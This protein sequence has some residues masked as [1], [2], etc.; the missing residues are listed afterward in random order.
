[1]DRLAQF[2]RRQTCK[3]SRPARP[4]SLPTGASVLYRTAVVTTPHVVTAKRRTA[5]SALVSLL[6]VSGRL[7]R[8]FPRPE[9]D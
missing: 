6:M 4:K 7:A 8:A 3:Q 9:T 1:M 2:E 5:V